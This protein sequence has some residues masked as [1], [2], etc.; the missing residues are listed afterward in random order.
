MFPQLNREEWQEV[1]WHVVGKTGECA[2]QAA[3]RQA[4]DGL[5]SKPG[6]GLPFLDAGLLDAVLWLKKMK[7]GESAPA[8]VKAAK[9]NAAEQTY[10]RK[11]S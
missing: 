2:A 9:G 10:R 7:G 3:D 1:E 6:K 11:D 5:G 8:L 4:A